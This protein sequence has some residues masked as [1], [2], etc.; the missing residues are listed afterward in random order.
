MRNGRILMKLLLYNLR[1]RD[2]TCYITVTDRADTINVLLNDTFERFVKVF[3][4][5][6][7]RRESRLIVHRI[8]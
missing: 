6:Q 2:I 7:R 1:D 4:H 3:K 8:I 5:Q